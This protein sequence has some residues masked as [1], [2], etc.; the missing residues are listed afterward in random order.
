MRDDFCCARDHFGTG[1]EGFQGK[2]VTSVMVWESLGQF[3]PAQ[4]T[5]R[6]IRFRH[7][8]QPHVLLT[9]NAG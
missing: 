8:M 7:T 4:T 3:C 5:G 1:A 2:D 9:E 6:G